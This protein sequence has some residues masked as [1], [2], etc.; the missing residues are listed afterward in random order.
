MSGSGPAGDP[1]EN[2][3]SGPGHDLLS[4]LAG[5]EA[6]QERTVAD[7][8]RRVVSTSLGVIREQKAGRRRGRSMALAAALVVFVLLGPLVWW[9][10]S[11]LVEEEHLAGLMGQL[12]VW[13]FLLSAALLGSVLLAGWVRR[14][15]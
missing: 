7:K 5:H 3:Q 6:D 10:V 13:A 8:A 4:A 12:V 11:E 14:R 1:R 9:A 15:P 2:P